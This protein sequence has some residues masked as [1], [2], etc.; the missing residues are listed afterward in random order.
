M[1]TTEAV[2]SRAAKI[3]LGLV[4]LASIATALGSLEYILGDPENFSYPFTDKYQ[5]HLLLVRTHGVAAAL[6]LL[7]GPLGFIEKLGYHRQ[8]GQLYMLGVLLGTLTAI[9]MSLMAEGGLSSQVGFM[10]MSLLWGYTGFQAW[11]SARARDFT[12]HRLWVFRNFALSFGAVVFRA[13]LYHMQ[14][15]GFAFHDI[16]PSAVW[17]CWVPVMLVAESLASRRKLSRG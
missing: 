13:Y 8:R 4:L 7:L 17:V 9:P 1:E 3:F 14:S 2:T 11:R 5:R 16:Y 15:A 10:V 6:T 12:E